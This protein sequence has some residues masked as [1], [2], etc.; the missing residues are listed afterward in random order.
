MSD[1]T[2]DQQVLAER[3]RGDTLATIAGRHDLSIEGVRY[4]ANRAARRHVAEVL[5]NMWD[6]Q[7]R[8]DLL[9]LAIPDASEPDQQQAIDYLRWLIHEM[10]APVQLRIHYRPTVD[11]HIVFALEDQAYNDTTSS[12]EAAR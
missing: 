4:V 9:V 7:N 12:E 10:P 2:R 1:H 6:A 5:C 3:R 11:G 8:G